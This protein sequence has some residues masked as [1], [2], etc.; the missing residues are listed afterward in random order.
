M[1][2]KEKL[3]G[4]QPSQGVCQHDLCFLIYFL[5][6]GYLIMTI[7]PFRR[8]CHVRI[9]GVLLGASRAQ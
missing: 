4:I 3:L 5:L 8:F 7:L 1:F 6:S 2:L 9:G